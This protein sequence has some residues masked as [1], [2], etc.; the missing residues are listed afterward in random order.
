MAALVIYLGLNP[1]RSC[2][3]VYR[4]EVRNCRQVFWVII[5]TLVDYRRGKLPLVPVISGP[6]AVADDASLQEKL[7]RQ[8][9]TR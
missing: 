4:Y 5:D 2:H 6:N 1:I 3:D 8:I 7:F 9:E